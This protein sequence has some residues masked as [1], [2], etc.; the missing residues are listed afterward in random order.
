VEDKSMTARGYTFE[1]AFA[2]VAD[3]PTMTWYEPNGLTGENGQPL[4]RVNRKLFNEQKTYLNGYTLI[5][6]L[7][8]VENN[9]GAYYEENGNLDP[10]G[11]SL[12]RVNRIVS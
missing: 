7:R 4:Y 1:E 8:E 3:D 9:P 5:E 2:I 10:N 11:N 12:Y 6:A